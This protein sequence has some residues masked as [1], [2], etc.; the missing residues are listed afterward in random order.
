MGLWLIFNFNL[1]KIEVLLILTLLKLK[2]FKRKLEDQLEKYMGKREIIMVTGPRQ[3]GK[4]TLLQHVDAEL[5][6]DSVFLSFEDREMLEV[7]EN[8]VKTFEKMYV[9][10]KQ[11]VFIDEFQYAKEGGQKL[12]FL[13][14]KTGKK[15][16]V[17]GSSSLE[18]RGDV[19]KYLVGRV[20]MFDLWPFSFEEFVRVRGGRLGELLGEG[21]EA[22]NKVLDFEV[23][24]LGSGGIKSESMQK[25]LTNL[26][27]E[28]VVWGGYPRVLQA[29][30]RE[31]KELVLKNILETYLLKDIKDLLGLASDRELM[32][33][34]RF[35]GVQMGNV[36]VYKE[37]GKAAGLS[38]KQV[39]RHLTILEET[40]VLDR[41]RP[42][43]RNKKKE[44]VKS[45]KVYFV[46]TGL[47][48]QLIGNFSDLSLRGDKG[49]LFENY[50]FGQL[51][52]RGWEVKF[53]RTKAKAEVDFVVER[54]GKL[55]AVEVK[56]GLV[57]NKVGKSLYSFIEKYS[58]E[59]VL[60][61][62]DGW[63]GRRQVK[64]CVV[65]FVPGYYL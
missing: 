9:R 38:F 62:T 31:E 14:D 24:E 11:V 39:K 41:V 19:G 5:E 16:V 60:V 6:Q 34:A 55:M 33:L 64:D 18:L 8:D 46:D 32:E 49:A 50:V 26:L 45:P 54:E 2:Y 3:A 21:R 48:N 10:D 20:F 7:F 56:M 44:L 25:R 59:R 17:S 1:A 65:N 40:F 30:S 52:R 37:L 43:F 35:L 28:Y 22:V 57:D 27:Y 63:E 58:P 29:E 12:K 47:R 61:I 15:F 13:F 42:F 4:T 51:A 36:V 53:W 23:K